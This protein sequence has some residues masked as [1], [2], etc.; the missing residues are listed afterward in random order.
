MNAKQKLTP[1]RFTP[2]APAWRAV[3]FEQLKKL[4]ILLAFGSIIS[5]SSAAKATENYST[6]EY[7][8]TTYCIGI[9]TGEY[10]WPGTNEGG[11]P[12]RLPYASSLADAGSNP[13]T[14]TYWTLDDAAW[15]F[16]TTKIGD[17]NA[18]AA[19]LT[20]DELIQAAFPGK[21]AATG[22]G[23]SNRIRGYLNGSYEENWKDTSPK[24]PSCGFAPSTPIDGPTRLR[25]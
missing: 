1:A 6:F 22:I 7:E 25:K 12:K 3:G 13:P 19:A 15:G 8:G 9:A 2:A 23:G 17:N 4:S 11:N 18:F 21:Y 16:A 10:A 20:G 24:P 5:S 14:K